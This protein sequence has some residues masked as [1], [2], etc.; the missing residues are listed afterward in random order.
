MGAFSTIVFVFSI[1]Q[2]CVV[3]GTFND[4]LS[5]PTQNWVDVLE[6]GDVNVNTEPYDQSE[7]GLSGAATVFG[8]CTMYLLVF[9]LIATVYS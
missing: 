7:V 3:H 5:I 4:T 8:S 2:L 6:D 1:L 9:I